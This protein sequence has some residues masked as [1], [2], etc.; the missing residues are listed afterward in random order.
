MHACVVRLAGQQPPKIPFSLPL[1]AGMAGNDDSH[2]FF[3]FTW[4]LRI[5]TQT[6][7]L[8]EQAFLFTEPS[9]QPQVSFLTFVN[10]KTSVLSI[11]V[12]STVTT[13]RRPQNP[14]WLQI[15]QVLSY[16][17]QGSTS[18]VGAMASKLQ[19]AWVSQSSSTLHHTLFSCMDLA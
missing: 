19:P 2:A 11:L 4:V 7:L 16:S 6:F 15:S 13:R 8:S 3:H 14:L 1:S 17:A 12:N 18:R 5:R 10:S 9:H